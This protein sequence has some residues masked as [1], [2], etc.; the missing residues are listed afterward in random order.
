MAGIFTDIFSQFSYLN[1][2]H[3]NTVF[4]DQIIMFYS[5]KN[6]IELDPMKR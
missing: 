1:F 6:L 2:Y 4:A 5:R 3:H